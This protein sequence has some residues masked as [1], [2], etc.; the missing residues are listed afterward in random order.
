[1]ASIHGDSSYYKETPIKDFYLD[2][3]QAESYEVPASIDDEQ[4]VISSKYHRRPDLLAYDLFGDS[5]LWW[6]F[7][8]RNKDLLIDPINDFVSGLE[9]WIPSNAGAQR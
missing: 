7:P 6:I 8:M 1:M 9:I 4:M 2:L 5:K 3:W